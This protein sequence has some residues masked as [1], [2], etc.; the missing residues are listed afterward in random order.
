MKTFYR[1][2]LWCLLLVM[3]LV[4]AAAALAQD[5]TPE[6]AAAPNSARAER[7]P[8]AYQLAGFT[9]HAQMWN[10]CG[11]ATLTM[12]LSYYGYTD[13]QVRA[14]NWLKPNSED[15]N[16]S[17]WQMAF[18]V[19]NQVPELPVYALVR[20]GGTLEL[21]KRLIA[22]DFPVII[23]EGYD[24]PRAAQGWM[25][26]YLLIIGYDDTAQQFMTHDSYDGANHPYSYE[27]IAEFWQHFNYTYLVVYESGREPE[28]L[29][30]LG[31]DADPAQNVINALGIAQAEATANS[32]D[33]FAWHN[34]GSNYTMLA[35][36]FPADAQTYY[37]YAALSFDEA[38]RAGDG[39]P[40]RMLWYQFYM[41][42]AYFAVGRYDDMITLAQA[43]LNDGG[44]QYV[45]ETF[46]YGGLAREGKGEYERAL[47]NYN[48]A[49]RFNPNFTP[50]IER[51][52][53]LQ[54]RLS[55]SSG[56]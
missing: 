17:P 31:S 43:K 47:N 22:N 21:L 54:I 5:S 40:W 49:L 11:P 39:L 33:P 27:H 3:I 9:Y 8:P 45:E 25:G 14:A 41:Y 44:G 7:L 46:Y 4:P 24:P 28:L 16:V 29:E 30:L 53:A 18:F 6:P 15:K 1:I 56:G 23:E 55:G 2:L 36:Y 37:E 51:R 20:Y 10:N 34:L 48:E 13:D 38:T 52:D 12:A 32:A 26:H 50:A 35:T 42:E 19:N